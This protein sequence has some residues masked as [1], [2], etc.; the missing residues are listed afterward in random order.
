MRRNYNSYTPHSKLILEVCPN[1]GKRTSLQFEEQPDETSGMVSPGEPPRAEKSGRY[2]HAVRR[3][4][5]DIL[6][7]HKTVMISAALATS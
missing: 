2:G 3:Q 5:L 1:C 6:N 7:F 4:V